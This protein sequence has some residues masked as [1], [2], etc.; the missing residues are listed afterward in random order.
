VSSRVALLAVVAALAAMG[1]GLLLVGFENGPG[2][3]DT[4]VYRL[5]GERMAGGDLPYR[6]F[7]VEYPP[8]ALVAFLLPALVSSTADGFDLAFETLMVVALAVVSV[9]IVLTLAALHATVGRTLVSVGAFLAGVALLGPFVLTRFDL[10][11]GAATLGAVC[12]VLHS[13]DRLGSVLLGLAIATKLYP[14]VLL[15]LLVA[16][17]W[18]REGSTAALQCLGLTVGTALVVYLPFAV[19]APTGV[20][21][22]VWRQ[23]GRPLQI[24]SLG[25]GVLLAFH[26]VAGMPLAWASGAGSQ[27]LT[28]TVAGVASAV[29][30]VVGL[31]A[32]VLV[33]ARFVRGDT[34][35][36][37]RFARY[38][39]AAVV[40]FV[41]FGKVASPQFLVW[42]L[43]VVVLVP[44][45]R[46]T[47][48]ATLLLASCGL[49]RMWFPR[50][51]WDLV[52]QFDPAA[53]WLVLAR[54]LLLV[55]VFVVLVA[56]LRAREGERA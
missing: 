48:A 37:A 54:D 51:Y 11:A 12:A 8:G 27:N 3:T 20:M 19:L 6:D 13:R 16:R 42:L 4:P 14:A 2:I 15:P 22:S 32:L 33:W 41:A 49:T 10:Y 9:L 30:T 55:G 47:L 40:A 17:V 21:R 26:H 35:N 5:Y 24:E 50:S 38:S 34:A 43:A 46:G 1:T 53:S 23:V 45:R 25:S 39:A 52:Q 44:G 18:R 28:G 29:T 36:A 7:A 56:R 31:A